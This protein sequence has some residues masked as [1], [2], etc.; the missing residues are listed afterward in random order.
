MDEKRL[1]QEYR[2]LKRQ[3][4]PDLWNRIEANLKDFP[5]RSA[6]A[7]KISRQEENRQEENGQEKSANLRPQKVNSN[8]VNSQKI[9][10]RN[11]GKFLSGRLVYGM[12]AAA[13][14][15]IVF[16]SVPRLFRG[17]M[18]NYVWRNSFA[19]SS[20][21]EAETAMIT[22]GNAD[23]A[24]P[25]AVPEAGV[26]AAD[27]E[28]IPEVGAGMPNET[29]MPEFEA[30]M[31][32]ETAMPE[33]GAGIPGETAM[34]EFEAGMSGE[35]ATP[36]NEAGMPGKGT[37]SEGKAGMSGKE[38]VQ[39][40]GAGLSDD[41][42]TSGI[43]S[44][45]DGNDRSSE[46]VLPDGVLNNEQLALAAY[47]PLALPDNVVSVS[48]D[49]WYFSEG[50]LK[51]TQLLCGGTV[52]SVALEEDDSGRT[53]KVVYEIVLNQ[54]Y[55]S[56]DYTAGM[57]KIVVK[58]PIIRTGGDEAYV[59]YQ[60]QPGGTYLLPLQKPGADWELLYPF[61]P[62][63]QVTAGDGYLFHTGYKSLINQD[64][65]VVVGQPEGEN[66]YYYDRMVFREDDEFLTE[67]LALVE[68]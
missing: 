2:K 18:K 59:L 6:T 37:V 25:M 31:P 48:E 60:L 42:N 29:A 46:D 20:R 43:P 55:F 10:G 19:K 38:A 44:F 33:F 1:E 53:A 49:S 28:V 36:K 8:K 13:A 7:L 40:S 27:E 65:W 5:E 52:A 30:G 62:Q 56:E 32:S 16:V 64:T 35:G 51:D 17:Q 22:G 4:T 54:V 67:F 21:Q 61:A 3:E 68:H 39:E 45:S 24:P 57:D 41:T 12:A 15:V 34:P 9:N 47:Q 58:S 66:D 26:A 63:I 50:I 14:M 11:S 23:M